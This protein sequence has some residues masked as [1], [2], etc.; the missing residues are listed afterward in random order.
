MPLE[1]TKVNAKK[2]PHLALCHE[3]QGFSAN[4]RSVSLLMKSGGEFSEEVQKALVALGYD[5]NHTLVKAFYSQIQTQLTE[6]IQE[7]YCDHEDDWLYVEDFDETQAIFCIEGCLYSVKYSNSDGVITVDDTATPVIRMVSYDPVEGK[8]EL[9]EQAE[10]MI[11]DGT[12][13]LVK[14]AL[15]NPETVKRLETIFKTAINKD[16]Q[17]LKSKV[18]DTP[19]KEEIEKAVAAVE[20]LLKAQIQAQ[21]EALEKASARIKELEQTAVTKSRKE[22]LASVEED[23]TKLDALVKSLETLGDEAFA[24]VAATMVEK[25]KAVENSDLFK[26]HSVQMKVEES[27]EGSFDALM[28]AKYGVK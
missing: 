25:A 27:E 18:Q 11:E 20:T 15:N 28:K 6:Q 26:Q 23:A 7:L 16:N 17:P 14:K 19:L 5:V 22:V 21:T 24:V 2:T 1:I 8:I 10:D 9:S 3:D 13:K 4:N 12:Y